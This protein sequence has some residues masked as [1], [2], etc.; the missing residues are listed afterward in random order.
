MSENNTKKITTPGIY[1]MSASV[2]HG[3]PCLEPSLSAS[4]L[5]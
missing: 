1:D 5:K 2:Y 3:D 4:I